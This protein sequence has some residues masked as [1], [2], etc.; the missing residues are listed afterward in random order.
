MPPSVSGW[1]LAGAAVV[2]G[3]GGGDV[4]GGGGGAVVVVVV[5]GR[6]VVVGAGT[7]ST[8]VVGVVERPHAL[9]SAT[10]LAFFGRRMGLAPERSA[11]V[12]PLLTTK[13]VDPFGH[14]CVTFKVDEPHAVTTFFVTFLCPV[15]AF[16][17]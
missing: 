2:G 3:D 8:A 17:H 13:I 12:A 5:G 4:V 16:V 1:Q 14:G 7:V 10:R 11:Y 15:A 6:V 9:L